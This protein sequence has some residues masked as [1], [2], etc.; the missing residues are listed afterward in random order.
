MT[1]TRRPDG[2]VIGSLIAISF[3]TV[4]MMVNSSGLPAPWPLV[5]RAAGA[6]IAAVLVVALLRT[7]RT[8]RTTSPEGAGFADRRYQV[9][10]AVEVIALFGG[11]YVINQVLQRPETGIA[12]VAVVVGTH[13]FA[14]AWAWRLPLFHWLGAAMTLLGLAGFVA[15]ALGASAATV[16]LIAGVGSGLSLYGTVAAALLQARDSRYTAPV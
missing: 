8:G 2:M 9:I 10:V 3:G 15:Y 14:L 1:G 5:I 6:V 4:F 7:A 12:W 11:L 13:F 16:A